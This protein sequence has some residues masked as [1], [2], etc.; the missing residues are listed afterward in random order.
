MK[1]RGAKHNP[2]KK[3]FIGMFGVGVGGKA[4]SKNNISC[5]EHDRVLM[6][7]NCCKDP[8][9]DG[10]SSIYKVATMYEHNAR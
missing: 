9:Y 4:V 7:N 2:F 10:V 6:M 8:V 3:C 5:D 1:I